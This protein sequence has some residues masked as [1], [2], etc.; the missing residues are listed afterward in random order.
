MLNRD[1]LLFLG[2]FVAVIVG[3]GT[4]SNASTPGFDEVA[5]LKADFPSNQVD[6]AL[7]KKS[8]ENIRRLIGLGKRCVERT[9]ICPYYYNGFFYEMP[10]WTAPAIY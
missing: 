2:G 4:L 7:Q 6:R 9:D 10:W 3:Y 5:V 1:A 8:D